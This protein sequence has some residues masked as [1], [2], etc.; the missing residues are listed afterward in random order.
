MQ[1]ER[2]HDRVRASARIERRVECAIGVDARDEV[3]V[4]A[5]VNRE[6]TGDQNLAV[7]LEDRAVHRAVRT[8]AGH[9]RHVQRAVAI[10]PREIRAVHGVQSRE[11]ARDDH[12]A[13]RLDRHGLHRAAHVDARRGE[14][15]IHA[16]VEVEPHDAALH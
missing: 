11:C 4:G 14:R 7:G 10:Q 13:I 12:L 15:R 8:G 6:R 9:E 1:R 5:V 3:G 2:A 16:R